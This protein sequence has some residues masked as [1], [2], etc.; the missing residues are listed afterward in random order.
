MTRAVSRECWCTGTLNSFVLA[1]QIELRALVKLVP[2]FILNG[3]GDR[4]AYS[5][6]YAFLVIVAF[7]YLLI[8]VAQCLP[9]LN[10][11]YRSAALRLE[12]YGLL[13]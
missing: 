12:Y 13:F 6:S 2:A 5:V 7:T 11:G 8:L 9:L 1:C 3:S 10:L 4:C